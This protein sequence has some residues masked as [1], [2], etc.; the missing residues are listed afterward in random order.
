MNKFLTGVMVGVGVGLLFA[1]FSG[2]E[3]RRRL[4][5]RWTALSQALPETGQEYVQH[6]TERVSQAGENLRGQAQEAV[7]V[8]KDAGSTLGDLAQRSAQEVQSASQN[9]AVHTKKTAN[10]VRKRNPSPTS[11]LSLGTEDEET[12]LCVED[13]S[14][15]CNA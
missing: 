8:A 9:V 1:P 3:T 10:T 4:A 12:E 6:V 2:E 15:A 7:S 13:I 11:P 5:E 14:E